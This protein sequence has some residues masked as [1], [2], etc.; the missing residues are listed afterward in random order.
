MNMKKVL[1]VCIHNTARS[2]IAETLFNSLAEAWRAESAG[3]EKAE[4]VDEK[5][6]EL[7]REKG[8]VAK[9]KPRTLDEISLDEF[10]LIVAVCE[11]G[12]CIVVPGREIERWYIEN[13]AG[14]DDETYRRVF[15]EIEEM[16]RQLVERLEGN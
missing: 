1:F 13:P 16:V 3:I 5:V 8:L 11:E 6:A 12:S 7:L 14:K 9:E 10:D 15:A 4:K 2:V